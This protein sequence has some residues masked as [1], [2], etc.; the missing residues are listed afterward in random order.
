MVFVLNKWVLERFSF[1]VLS[2]FVTYFFVHRTNQDASMLISYQTLC[3]LLF[4]RKNV[5]LKMT[6]EIFI[7]RGE[8]KN[9]VYQHKWMKRTSEWKQTHVSNAKYYYFL[10]GEILKKKKKRFLLNIILN[11][12]EI[13]NFGHTH[14]IN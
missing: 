12:W 7:E 3:N 14:I 9:F 6:R 13:L 10:F 1:S 4:M 2:P 5:Y 8:K 11:A